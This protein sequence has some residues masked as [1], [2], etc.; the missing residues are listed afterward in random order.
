MESNELIIQ[1]EVTINSLEQKI[2][3][4]PEPIIFKYLEKYRAAISSL[5][6][7]D[8]KSS[9]KIY[10]NKLL[11]CYRGYL[12]TSSNYKQDFLDEM[13]KSEELIKRLS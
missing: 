12:E 7:V 6:N 4:S 11:S 1:L 8:D 9:P 2:A 13:G 3:D 10:L 5:K